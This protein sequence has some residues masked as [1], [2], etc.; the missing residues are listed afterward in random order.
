MKYYIALI[1]KLFSRKCLIN[2]K[3]AVFWSGHRNSDEKVGDHDVL[4][5]RS[6]IDEEDSEAEENDCAYAIGNNVRNSS[7]DSWYPCGLCQLPRKQKT[8]FLKGI[9]DDDRK[10]LVKLETLSFLKISYQVVL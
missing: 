8:L 10:W 9:C 4:N 1:I 7:C 6:M 3:K 2:D 5:D